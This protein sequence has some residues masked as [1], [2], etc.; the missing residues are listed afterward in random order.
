MKSKLL[1][2]TLTL[3]IIFT[4]SVIADEAFDNVPP[5]R[6]LK[7]ALNL[8]DEQMMALG[9]LIDT[10]TA[11]VKALNEEKH[12]LQTQLE[13]LLH[14]EAPDQAEVGGMVLDIRGIKQEIRSV[15]ETY[16]QSFRELL[17]VMQLERLQHISQI[18]LADRAA[19]VLRELRLH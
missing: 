15:Q 6:V 19:E 8:S 7:V 12:V 1:L 3:T 18:A 17:T 11:E 16:Q 10:R 13:E 4:G 14:S 2:A 5:A 9:E